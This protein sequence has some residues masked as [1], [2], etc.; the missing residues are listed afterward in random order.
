MHLVLVDPRLVG[1]L[2]AVDLLLLEPEVDLLLGRV[3]TVGAVA[4]VAADILGDTVSMRSWVLL[5][6]V[7]GLTMAKSPRMVPGW[8]AIGLVAPRS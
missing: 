6:S 3:D 4:D 5:A 8:E 7:D 2:P 1:L